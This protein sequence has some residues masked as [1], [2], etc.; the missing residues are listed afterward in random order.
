MHR[1]GHKHFRFALKLAVF[2]ILAACGGSESTAPN[3]GEGPGLVTDPA[4]AQIVTTDLAHFWAAYD[5]GGKNGSTAEFQSKYLDIASAG[6]RDF[7]QS[8]NITAASLTQMVAADPRYF[9]SIRSSNLA[10]ATDNS[11]A[12][13]IRANF[14]TIKS[15]YPAAVFPPVTLLIGRFS[16]GGTTSSNGMLIGTEFYSMTAGTPLDELGTFQRTNVKSADSLPIIVSHEHAHILQALAN[17]VFSHSNKNL[18]EQSLMEGG[19]DFVGERSSGGNINAWLWPIALPMESALWAE[20][21]SAMHGTDVSRWLYN[22]GS[23]TATPAR[24]GDLGY[25]IGYRIAQAYYMK[26]ADKTSALRDIIEMKDADA[27]LAASGYAP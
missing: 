3:S 10:F 14:A 23:S 2:L 5:A 9:A 24:P 18:L 1:P 4:A 11:L 13:R 21:K 26:Q 25:F 8:R 27:F 20:F 17:G 16:S 7:I 19:A 22:Q 12:Q 6:L 15:L